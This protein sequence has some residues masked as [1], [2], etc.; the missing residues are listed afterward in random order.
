MK[1]Y[2]RILLIFFYFA[3][4]KKTESINPTLERISESVYAS[5]IIK[6]K[7]QYQLYSTV[8]GI[9]THIYKKEGELIKAGEPVF[10][11][12]NEVSQLQTEN[13]Q[14]NASY[15]DYSVQKAKLNELKVNINLAAVKVSQDSLLLVRQK[16]LW[17]KQIG[18][19]FEL[20]QRELALK[21]SRS[22]F[23]ASKIRYQD[24]KNQIELAAKLSKKQLEISKN[25]NDDYRIVSKMNGKIYSVLKKEGELVSPQFPIVIIGD[26]DS[27]LIELQVDESD[28]SKL[29]LQ[30]TVLV[31]LDSY[32]DRVFEAKVAKIYPMMNERSRTFTIEATFKEHP[33]VLY[34]N[35]TVEANIV[36]IT[37]EQA[38]TIPK[39]FVS[40]DSF[41]ILNSNEKRKVKIGVSDYQKVEILEGITQN[42]V[43]YKPGK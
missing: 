2:I 20:E 31:Q 11:V 30:Q 3:C 26:A 17:D 9:L 36:L 41:V 37:K 29:K 18:S 39:S 25:I 16:A 19:L 28:I 12:L 7:N 38:L 35:L 27:F 22:I 4:S 34:P 21:N 40:A 10:K 8:S 24:L 6:S 23:Q 5:G 15:M 13:A 43:L 14:L 32:E 33:P 1:F 42:D